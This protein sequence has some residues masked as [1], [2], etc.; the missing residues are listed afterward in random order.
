MGQTEIEQFLKDGKFHYANEISDA[1]GKTISTVQKSLSQM[2]KYR[3][4][5]M[6]KQPKQVKCKGGTR[7]KIVAVYAI[8]K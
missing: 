3:E 5:V 7:I 8:R 6:K 1:I 4:I 2:A